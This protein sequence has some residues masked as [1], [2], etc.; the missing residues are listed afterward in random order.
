MPNVLNY[1]NFITA[2]KN[3]ID[4]CITL[5]LEYCKP[6]IINLNF[7]NVILFN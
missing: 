1:N 3:Y 5:V 6:C 2:Q 7:I 4:N